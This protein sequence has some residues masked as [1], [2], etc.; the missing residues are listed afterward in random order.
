MIKDSSND[1]LVKNSSQNSTLNE[2]VNES[3]SVIEKNKDFFSG[4]SKYLSEIE[5][6]FEI[7]IEPQIIIC[8]IDET[9]PKF[10]NA[11]DKYLFFWSP[12]PKEC[13]EKSTSHSAY[14]DMK[15]CNSFSY[16]QIFECNGFEKEVQ[17]SNGS[18]FGKVNILISI[19]KKGI[20]KHF[21]IDHPK[22]S[23]MFEFG[24]DLNKDI[25]SHANE[26]EKIKDYF[27]CALSTNPKDLEDW[28]INY[29]S[30]IDWR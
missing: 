26:I 29:L 19:S 28:V 27:N 21:R 4:K 5:K 8:G 20:T 10:N 2:S 30:S 25:K 14:I 17:K 13:F 22:V 12:T 1:S 23:Y 7:I 6:K 3:D 11:F 9:V 16:L 15:N 18:Q 24:L